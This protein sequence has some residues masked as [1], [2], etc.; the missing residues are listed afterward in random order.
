MEARYAVSAAIGHDQ[1][2]YH[3]RP[4][5]D[6]VQADNTG[7]GLTARFGSGGVEIGSG[8]Q[9]ILLQ[10]VAWGHGEE[11]APAAGS[12]AA[13]LWEYSCQHS[14]FCQ[15][16][17]YKWSAGPAA[18][19]Y[20]CRSLREGWQRRVEGCL[21]IDG[22]YAAV[23]MP[24][25][26]GQCLRESMVLLCIATAVWWCGMPMAARH[27]HGLRRRAVCCISVLMTQD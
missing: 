11:L 27:R 16:M 19:L 24:M 25:V 18:G 4:Y 13:V 2:G 26:S 1:S 17:V 9:H 21:F 5:G 7:H 14:R 12:C 6:V 8:G 3:A 10:P 20:D 22:A 23:L 15:R